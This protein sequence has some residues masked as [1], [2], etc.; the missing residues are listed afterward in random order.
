M[1]IYEFFPVLPKQV[2]LSCWSDILVWRSCGERSDSFAQV[3]RNS[4]PEFRLSPPETIS[5]AR[6]SQ[7]WPLKISPPVIAEDFGGGG[8]SPRRP[9]PTHGPVNGRCRRT[10][11]RWRDE[12]SE[13]LRG[14]S[15]PPS[16]T[17]PAGRHLPA[18]FLSSVTTPA[19]M[20]WPAEFLDDLA[21]VCI[22][23]IE[24]NRLRANKMRK[25]SLLL[26]PARWYVFS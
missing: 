23:I 24:R 25:L 1:T 18:E 3:L 5:P 22:I 20:N 13:G 10:T 15:S 12:R 6:L 17:T 21:G 9:V 11:V 19:E 14:D 26:R 8:L 7:I 4:R 16:D 2:R